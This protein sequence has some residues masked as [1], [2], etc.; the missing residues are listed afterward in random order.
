M[1]DDGYDDGYDDVPVYRSIAGVGCLGVATHAVVDHALEEEVTCRGFAGYGHASIWGQLGRSASADSLEAAY[2]EAHA[3]RGLS[4]LLSST[5]V[6]ASSRST[7]VPFYLPLVCAALVALA[8]RSCTYTV[9]TS[10]S[11]SSSSSG[12]NST[13]GSGSS[14]RR[15][16]A[17][18]GA[19]TD[20]APPPASSSIC[21]PSSSTRSPFHL[22]EP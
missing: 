22:L 17:T 14:R 6:E 15:S 16:T 21:P 3:Y 11:S 13:S 7:A 8:G 19:C 4:A 1:L 18:T 2:P 12:G 20:P 10:S 9:F 5:H